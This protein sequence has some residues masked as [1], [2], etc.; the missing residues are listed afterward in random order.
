MSE[1]WPQVVGIGST[2]YDTLMVTEG[3]PQE[4]TKMLGVE[5]KIQ[6]GGP[7]AT[8]LVAAAKLGVSSAYLGTVGDDPFGRYLMEDLEAWK[9]DVTHVRRVPEAVSFHAVVLLNRQKGTRTCVWSPGTVPPPTPGDIPEEALAHAKVLHLDGHMLQAA[10]HAARLC[11]GLGVKVSHDAG[12]AYPGIET[13]LPYVDYLIPSEEF[14]MK[15]TGAASPEDAARQLYDAYHPEL[16]ALTQGVRGGILL[17][18]Q[19]MRRYESYPVEVVD[20]NGCGDTF[21]GAFV[22]ARV[23][24]M[25]PDAACRF[26]SAAA[27]LKCTRLGARIGIPTEAECL[28]FIQERGIVL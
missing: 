27:A 3:F 26:A 20:S 18:A 13:L 10:I 6:G 12:G 15:I 17:D 7:C 25:G 5:T 2:V 1:R 28:A 24:G 22:A 4:D 11:K 14:A 8:A 16:V 23:K 19:G 21:H 9:V